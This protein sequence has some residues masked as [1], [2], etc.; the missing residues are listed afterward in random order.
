[1]SAL[2]YTSENLGENMCT[3]ALFLNELPMRNKFALTFLPWKM[4]FVQYLEWMY[5]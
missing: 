4:P 1:M 2:T 3:N 5:I